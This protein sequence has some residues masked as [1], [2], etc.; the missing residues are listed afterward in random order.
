[1]IEAKSAEQRPF[2]TKLSIQTFNTKN[3]NWIKPDQYYT[4]NFFEGYMFTN[5]LHFQVN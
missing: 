1:L 4:K 3:R 5:F 2:S